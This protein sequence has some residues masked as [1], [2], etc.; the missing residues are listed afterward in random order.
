MLTGIHILFVGGD[1]RQLEVIR[2]CIELDANAYLVGYD[3][4]DSGFI[5]S[6]K[7]ELLPETLNKYDAIVLPVSGVDE[8]GFVES[9]FTTHPV[10]L[11]ES[12]FTYLKKSCTVY[13]GIANQYLKEICSKL[14]IPLIPLMDR[15][16][17]AIYNSIPTVEGTLMLA[18]QNTDFTIHRSNCMVLGLGRVGMSLSRALHALGAFVTVVVRKPEDMARAYEM[19]LN[20]LDLRDL[21]QNVSDVDILFNTIPHKVVTAEVIANLKPTALLIDLASKPGGCDFR[22]AEK[23]GIKAILAPGLPGIVAPKTAGQII[24]NTLVRLLMESNNTTGRGL[25]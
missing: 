3:N 25:H 24:A 6:T 8:K 14:Q 20:Q 15:D 9:I 23:R 10:Q 18:I 1:A 12:H 11:K 17:V 19:G 5:G 7:V 16:D 22:F 21:K 2:K 4:L 13:T